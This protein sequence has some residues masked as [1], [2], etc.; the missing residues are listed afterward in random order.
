MEQWDNSVVYVEGLPSQAALMETTMVHHIRSTMINLNGLNGFLERAFLSYNPNQEGPLLQRSRK[1]T[2][3][4]TC[5]EYHHQQHR[6]Q[7]ETSG[8]RRLVPGILSEL[9]LGSQSFRYQGFVAEACSLGLW[10]WEPVWICCKTVVV[11]FV[12]THASCVQ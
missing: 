1:R 2:H 9:G 11:D 10:T 5:R 6:C 4:F 12:G 3:C 7:D 8:Y